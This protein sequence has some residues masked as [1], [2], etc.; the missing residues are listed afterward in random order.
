M[1]VKQGDKF[2]VKSEDGSKN[3]GGPYETREQAAKR[4]R[5][6]EYFKHN[7]GR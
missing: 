3:L 2:Y 1:I 4:L 6:V 7:G 5:E